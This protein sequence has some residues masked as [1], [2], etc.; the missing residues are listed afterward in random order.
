MPTAAIAIK[1]K[2]PCNDLYSSIM[3]TGMVTVLHTSNTIKECRQKLAESRPNVLLLG[4]DLPGNREDANWIDFCR[5]VHEEYPALKILTV[6]SFDEYLKHKESLNSLTSGYI[7]KE[8]LPNMIIT[9]IETVNHGNFFRYDQAVDTVQE[10]VPDE[11]F[12]TLNK[13]ILESLVTGNIN[14]EEVE[15]ISNF[16]DTI[17][18][19]HLD[20][21]K[22][23][24]A[25]EKENPDV[26]NWG[27]N[28]LKRFIE[29]L[30]IKGYS[31]WAIADLFEID[32]KTVRLYRLDFILQI[33]G[34]NSMAY[35]RKDGEAVHFEQKELLLLKLIAAGYTSEEI[36]HKILY[37]AVDTIKSERKILLEKSGAR[38]TMAM[39][40]DALRMG[41]IKMEDILEDI[42]LY[43]DKID[44]V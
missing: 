15:R 4:L 18:K 10:D 34:N 17:E 37:K 23:L 36:G 13:E 26:D 14:R 21:L 33:R 32:I 44:G 31:N 40:I 20:I 27:E 30:F 3:R 41:L 42:D 2:K 8:A 9:A 16:I 25:K 6:I 29:K 39:V 22:K 5:R 1:N 12:D 35:I 11:R 43:H 38:N 19:I 24:L 28:Y 7:S